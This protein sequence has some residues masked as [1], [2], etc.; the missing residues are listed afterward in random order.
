MPV[1]RKTAIPLLVYLWSAAISFPPQ[2][3]CSDV[4]QVVFSLGLYPIRGTL[5]GLSL[6]QKNSPG[7]VEFH[8]GFILALA[9]VTRDMK[10]PARQPRCTF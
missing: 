4:P 8:R 9:G 7:A 6:A 5:N 1:A 10:R 2:D 3:L